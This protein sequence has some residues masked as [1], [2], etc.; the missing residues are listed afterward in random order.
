MLNELDLPLGVVTSING[1]VRYRRRGD[2]HGQPC[3]HHADGPPARRRRRRGRAGAVRGAARARPVRTRW[4]RWA[5][6]RCPAARSTSCLAAASSASTCAPP[7]TPSATPASHDVLAELEAHLRAPRPALHARGDHA[8]RAAPSAP[9]WQ[10]RWEK[11]VAA[12]GLPLL[13][14]AQRRRPRR[15]EAARGDAAGHAVRARQNAGI[16]HNPLES[17]TS[18]DMELC[19]QRLP[20]PPRTT[21]TPEQ[22]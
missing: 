13:P 16:S 17:T 3:R 12:L 20:A 6:C 21:C 19:V 2:R 18:D 4:R 15:D 10:Q 5:C 8:R 22:P 1:S 11:A 14:H 9:A 7:P